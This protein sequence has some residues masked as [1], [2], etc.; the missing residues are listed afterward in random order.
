MSIILHGYSGGIHRA[1]FRRRGNGVGYED[2]DT[3]NR[4]RAF[5]RTGSSI[6]W[7]GEK[8]G[9]SDSQ[10]M[11]RNFFRAPHNWNLALNIFLLFASTFLAAAYKE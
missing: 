6:C 11:A 2:I 9:E 5:I 7:P 3:R 10:V 4:G 8:R 1:L